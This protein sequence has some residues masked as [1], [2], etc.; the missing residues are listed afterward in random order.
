[1]QN[2]KS[3][4]SH[5]HQQ[6]QNLGACS[7]F[8]GDESLQEVC[9]LL[10]SPQGREFV[11]AHRFPSIDVL[12]QFKVYGP[13]R[14]GV[15]IDAGEITLYDQEAFLI[16]DTQATLRY[17]SGGHHAI[18]MHGA[19]ATITAEG[20]SVVRIEKDSKSS[21]QLTISDYAKVLQ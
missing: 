8:K 20:Y 10:F 3:I 1:M 11:L 12:R 9:Q 7:L 21:Y 19:K 15:F 6:A 17:T 14:Y 2:Y 5:I 18:L 13:E 16:G 4:L